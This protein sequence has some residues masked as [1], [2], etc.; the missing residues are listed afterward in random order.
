MSILQFQGKYRFLSNFWN[1]PL[2]IKLGEYRFSNVECAYQAAKCIHEPMR[3]QFINV[4]PGEAKRLGRKVTMRKD[5]DKS[6]QEQ[7]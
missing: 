1:C 2:S 3:L 4:L 5:W 6:H 7:S